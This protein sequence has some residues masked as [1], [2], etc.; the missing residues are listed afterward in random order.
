MKILIHFLLCVFMATFSQSLFALAE[1]E[2]F[3]MALEVVLSDN[4]QLDC[5]NLTVCDSITDI[6][7]FDPSCYHDGFETLRPSEYND[8]LHMLFPYHE[9]VSN[10]LFFSRPTDTT[11]YAELFSIKQPDTQWLKMC[12]KYSIMTWFGE[13]TQYEITFK[14]NNEAVIKTKKTIYYN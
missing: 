10:V 8:C 3:H 6:V 9:G 7:V 4:P 2:K 1:C 5:H 11:I 13:S 12:T 14:E